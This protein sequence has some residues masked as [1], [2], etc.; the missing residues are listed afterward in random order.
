MIIFETAVQYPQPPGNNKRSTRTLQVKAMGTDLQ[1][2]NVLSHYSTL[3]LQDA[4][5][6]ERNPKIYN[7]LDH[8][9]NLEW[10]SVNKEW[11]MISPTTSVLIHPRKWGAS[12]SIL[13]EY[14]LAIINSNYR[15]LQRHCIGLYRGKY[16]KAKADKYIIEDRKS[17]RLNSSHVSQSRMPSSA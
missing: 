10:E 5:L 6:S 16:S 9:K 1:S 8:L 7:Y 2:P 17:T 12:A 14:D 3:I 4:I 15:I 11:Q 13:A